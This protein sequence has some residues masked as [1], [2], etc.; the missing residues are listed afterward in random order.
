VLTS[1]APGQTIKVTILR[2]DVEMELT[3]TLGTRPEGL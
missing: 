1:Y 3:I 2:N